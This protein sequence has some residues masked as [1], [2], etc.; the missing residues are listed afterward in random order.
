MFDKIN[1]FFLLNQ[2]TTLT[3]ELRHNVV[4]I[5]EYIKRHIR[6]KIIYIIKENF[7]YFR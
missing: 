5:D 7:V 1:F 3:I 2:W 6:T 4:F